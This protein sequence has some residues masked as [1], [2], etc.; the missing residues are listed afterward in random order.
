MRVCARRSGGIARRL[1]SE[2]VLAAVR[3]VE[4]LQGHHDRSGFRSGSGA[5]DRYFQ[6]Q[7]SQDAR[8]KIAAPFVLILADGAVAG[9]YTLSAASVGLAELPAEVCRKLPRYP[10]VP[11]T[12]L[13]RL[14]VHQDHQGRGHGRFLLADALYRALRNEIASFAVVVDAKDES[15]RRFYEREGFLSLADQPLRLFLP[16]ATVALAFR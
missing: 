14:A 13:G 1:A 9:F 2:R 6:V 8:R 10:M 4:P 16:M 5:L 12:L 11:A 3:R 15:A 7:A